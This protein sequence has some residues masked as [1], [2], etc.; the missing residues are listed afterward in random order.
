MCGAGCSSCSH[1]PPGD[2]TNRKQR[3]AQIQEQ[4][5]T[6]EEHSTSWDSLMLEL[7]SLRIKEDTEEFIQKSK[8]LANV[9]AY[10]TLLA[11][12]R[13]LKRRT[14]IIDSKFEAA[15]PEKKKVLTT[16]KD[17]MKNVKITIDNQL[18]LIEKELA[19]AG[20]CEETKP[21]K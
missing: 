9:V 17:A 5:E 4:L 8:D 6:E 15:T 11:A 10:N 18:N 13:V 14:K 20:T 3:I 1:T 21:K 12:S 19:T 7:K 16:L 2:G